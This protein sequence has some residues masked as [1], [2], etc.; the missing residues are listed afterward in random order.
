[1]LIPFIVPFIIA[2]FLAIN[3]GGSG[4]AAAFSAA[5]GADVIKKSLIPGLFG[6]M[7][8]LGAIIGGEET[9]RTVGRGI[10]EP[11]KMTYVIVSI[12]LLSV[13]LSLFFANL[14]GIPQSTSQAAVLA[15]SGPA[16]Y[17]GAFQGDMLFST[18]IPAWVIT[19]IA[20]YVIAFLLG[21]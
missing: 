12:I 5:Y 17:L 4:T 18:I 10:L 2:M 9:A 13:A 21:K 16:V 11:D 6:I 3:M 14:L 1:M 7:V 20:A 8:F 15:V 19:P